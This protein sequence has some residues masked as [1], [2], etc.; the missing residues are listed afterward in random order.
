MPTNDP[1]NKDVTNQGE[2]VEPKKKV[3]AKSV[4]AETPT[5]VTNP[6]TE[7]PVEGKKNLKRT[8]TLA[9]VSL[10]GLALLSLA[11]LSVL[12]YGYRSENSAVRAVSSVVPFPAERVNSSFV[13]YEDYLFTYD[14]YRQFYKSQT[15][16]D[17]KPLVDFNSADGQAKLKEL[18]EK[19]LDQL[20]S[21]AVVAQ[22][23][24]EQKLTVS[25]KEVDEA[26]QSTY[27]SN[28]GEKQVKEVLAKIYGWDIDDFER[29]L[30]KDLLAKKLE[31]KVTA[32]PKVDAQS[33]A[34][35]QDVLNQ[36][37]NG[38]DFGD[39]AKKYSQ[40]TASA[41]NG[42]DLG[43]FSKGQM[44]PEFEAASFALQPGQTS[45]LVK[46]KYGYHIIKVLEKKEDQVRASHVLVKT[47]DFNQYLQDKV[48][49]ASKQ[50]FIKA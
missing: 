29:V 48:K 50:S 16:A 42:G 41:A 38:A 5:P 21:D 4:S 15:G 10:A 30:R 34:K 6:G 22:L 47:V 8:L 20:A 9:G 46:T 18:R 7:A 26:L 11:V 28:G 19:V 2:T 36:A 31:Q 27:K 40:D 3:A 35:A 39:L 12:I 17:G 14:S 33:K 23:A 45:D 37:K 32:D 25:D 44:V 13:S 49:S 1:E 24:S 43:F